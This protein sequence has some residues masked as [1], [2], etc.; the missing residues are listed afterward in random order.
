VS[1]RSDFLVQLRAD[2][3]QVLSIPAAA[4]YPGRAPQKV[5]RVGLEVWIQSHEDESH[6]QGGGSQVRVHPF[7]IHL[8]LK[9][10]RESNLT[11]AAQLTQ[12]HEL[13]ETLHQRYAGTRPFA[14]ALP[15]LIA[16]EVEEGSVDEDPEDS[17]LLNGSL[18]LRVLER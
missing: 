5:S 3:A 15:D 18:V 16:I 10:R 9:S 8:R 14:L 7:A 1:F 12:V 13:L 2:L 6:A 17:D 4:V 11:G